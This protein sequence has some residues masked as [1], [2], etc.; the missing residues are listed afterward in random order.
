[1]MAL[2]IKLGLIPE[3]LNLKDR[4]VDNVVVMSG[5]H[6]ILLHPPPCSIT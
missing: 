1:M 5:V 3:G 2:D 4:T 6:E